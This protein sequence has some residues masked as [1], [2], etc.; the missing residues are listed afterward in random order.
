MN[1]FDKTVLFA[2]AVKDREC[3]TSVMLND[4]HADGETDFSVAKGVRLRAKNKV[5]TSEVQVF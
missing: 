1:Q 2:V 3:F 4:A 5:L